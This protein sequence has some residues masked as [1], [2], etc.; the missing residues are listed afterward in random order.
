M[1]LITQ[2]FVN[3]KI[4][5]WGWGREGKSTFQ[6]IKK[7]T[8]NA[9]I[10]IADSHSLNDI[11]LPFIK[12]AELVK[13]INEFDLIIKSPG[14]SLHNLNIEKTN[15][16]TSQVELFLKYYKNKTIGITGTKGKSTT[17]NL[18]YFLIKNY[19]DKLQIGGNIGI[20]VFDLLMNDSQSDWYVLEL[21]CH[22]LDQVMYSPHISILLNIFP[23]H[24]DYYHSFELYKQAKLNILTHQNSNDTAIINS[25]ISDIP[26]LKSEIWTFGQE[27]SNN[28]K[29]L[30]YNDNNLIFKDINQKRNIPINLEKLKLQGKHNIYNISAALLSAKIITS[31]D[32][33]EFISHIYEFQPLPHRL[34]YVGKY[35]NIYFYNDSISTIPQSTIAA[36]ES[37]NNVDTII[38]GG[39]NRGI[40]YTELIEYLK[41]STV[42]NIFCIG[43][44]K[45]NLYQNIANLRDKNVMKCNDLMQAVEAAYKFTLI[46]KICLLSP[47]AASYD[48]FK[49]FEERG[50]KFKEYIEYFGKKDK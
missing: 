20:P 9:D 41:K 15:N 7:F 48:Q 21:S 29:G 23:E 14:I 42:R 1:E 35:K 33:E 25:T 40:D 11:S 3:K 28:S 17:T 46:E 19:N 37:L 13:I 47:A 12:E 10:V 45:D 32:I 50:D 38:I 49:N 30:F 5:I 2:E 24:L 8:N 16:I 36:L 39:K 4:C 18:I 31:R 26:H 22:Q 44:L 6:F 43:E 27:T 34:E